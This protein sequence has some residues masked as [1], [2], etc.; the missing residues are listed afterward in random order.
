MIALG[1]LFFGI[2]MLGLAVLGLIADKVRIPFIERY[3]DTLP[4]WQEDEYV[5]RTRQRMSRHARAFK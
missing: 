4:D 5:T 1:A 3:L 2:F